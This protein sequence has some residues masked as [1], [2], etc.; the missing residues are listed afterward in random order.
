M[1]FEELI[2]PENIFR[3]WAEF[4]R[5][6]LGKLD[7]LKFDRYLEDNVFRLHD[8]LK[9]HTYQHQP[10]QTFHVYDPK[11]RIIS[12]AT[13][14]D[15]LVHHLVFDY[16]QSVFDKTFIYHSYSSRFEKGTHLAV[17][18]LTSALRKVS[19]NY[20]GTAY[21]LKCDIKRFFD[22]VSHQ[23]LFEIIK[24]RLRG[25]KILRLIKGIIQSFSMPV[26]KFSEKKKRE[27]ELQ[28]SKI[29]LPIG[30][31]TSQIFANIYLNK[32][33]QFIKHKLK[34]KHYFRYAD[35]FIIV[36]YS[37]AYLIKLQ[38]SI[39]NY[40]S[41]QLNLELHPNKISIRKLSQGIDFLGYVVL[42]FHIKL[43]TKTKQRM[44]KKLT[45]ARDQ[46]LKG[47]LTEYSFNQCLQSYLGLLRHGN[48]FTLSQAI[49]NDFKVGLVN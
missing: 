6:K 26:D 36:H 17:Y 28:D 3:A 1:T 5:G 43:R 33:D 19:H 10:Y 44:I 20:T 4:R 32:L 13:V 27:R 25:P 12:K 47:R 29:G 42:P 14:R 15:R 23:K 40:L 11:H 48:G 8:E 35:D 34:A 31:L 2:S 16:L 41:K 9:L 18:N 46:L 49:Q 45:L 22:N 21:A 37:R 30:N 24:K 38:Q 7:V 39:G